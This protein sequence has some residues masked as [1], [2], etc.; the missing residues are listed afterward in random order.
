M[1]LVFIPLTISSPF[2][3]T[4]TKKYPPQYIIQAP[5]DHIITT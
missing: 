3:K 1:L 5:N 2:Q 4:K